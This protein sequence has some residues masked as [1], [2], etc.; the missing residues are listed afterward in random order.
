MN[1]IK[2]FGTFSCV[3]LYRT[4][5]RGNQHGGQKCDDLQNWLD[6]TS[7]ENPLLWFL[8]GYCTPNQKLGC[9]C[10]LSQNYQ[11]LFD[12]WYMHLIENCPRN[13]KL[14]LNL[15]RPNGSWVIDQTIFLTVLIHNLKTTWSTK[16]SMPFFSIFEFLG[17][18][19]LKCIS[20]FKKVLIILR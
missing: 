14:A 3:F 10:V 17:Q 9:F 15:S 18:F 1:S 4:M 16:I 11:H 20:F 7:H 6:M 2:S 13:S 19:V 12:K 5:W 8:R